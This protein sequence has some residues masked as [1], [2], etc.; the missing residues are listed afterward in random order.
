MAALNASLQ[1]KRVEDDG[2]GASSIGLY[3]IHQRIRLYYGK[4]YGMQI[5][6]KEGKGTSVVLT[7]PHKGEKQ[8]ES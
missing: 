3:N 8:H 7:L 2:K 6:S 5:R 4:D 1:E